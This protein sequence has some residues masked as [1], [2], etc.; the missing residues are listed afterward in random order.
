M[1]FDVTL[2]EQSRLA[3]LLAQDLEERGADRVKI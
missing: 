3:E 2:S 1:D